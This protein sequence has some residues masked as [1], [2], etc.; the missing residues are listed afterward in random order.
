MFKFK[1]TFKYA[2]RTAA[3]DPARVTDP[4]LQQMAFLAERSFSSIF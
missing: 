2:E 3:R 1:C 4:G